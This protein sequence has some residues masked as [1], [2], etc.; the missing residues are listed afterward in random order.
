MI[1]STPFLFNA[2]LAAQTV[3][4]YEAWRKGHL[5]TIMKSTL[6]KIH[7]NAVGGK[8]EYLVEGVGKDVDLD[9]YMAE[10]VK[11]GY[12]VRPATAKESILARGVVIEW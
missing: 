8:R 7:E 3:A 10:L 2:A 9:A 5:P 6:S 11:L 4:T 1:T 12:R